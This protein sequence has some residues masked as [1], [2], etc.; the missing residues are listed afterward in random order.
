METEAAD[1]TR[2]SLTVARVL[3]APVLG[4]IAGASGTGKSHALRRFAADRPECLLLTVRA[5]ESRP[6]ALAE[7]IARPLGREARGHSLGGMSAWLAAALAAEPR[8]LILDDAHHAAPAALEWLAGLCEAA[9]VSAVLAGDLSLA[10]QVATLPQIAGRVRRPA[11]PD[12]VAEADAAAV[13]AAEG[14]A[15]PEALRLLT[16]AAALPGGLHNLRA[17]IE[18]AR[19]FAGEEPVAAAHVRAAAVDMK[20]NVRA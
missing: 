16:R 2:R 11:T 18:L 6:F 3:P 7:L 10:R 1:D 12:R 15:D 19:I 9:G 4:L 13:A 14:I 5:G 8:L 20:F 17:V